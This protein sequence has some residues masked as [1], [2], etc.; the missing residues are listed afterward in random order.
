MNSLHQ[1]ILRRLQTSAAS[2][3]FTSHDFLNL[4]SRVAVNQALSR[5]A[6]DGQVVR[7]GRGIFY[8]PKINPRLGISVPPAPDDVADALARQTGSRI[9]PSGATAANRLGLSTQV[10]AKAVYL[11]DGRSHRWRSG[12][13]D[14]QF[15][16]VSPRNFRPRHPISLL[17]FQALKH[18]GKDGVGDTTL[19]ALQSTLTPDQ[20]NA[21]SKDSRHA[22]DWIANLIHRLDKSDPTVQN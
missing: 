1:S 17:V 12:V 5:L 4:G 14:I 7:V 15:K 3:V 9:L 2:M 21:L 10:P 22:P 13:W 20:K 19:A 16:H 6:H 11:T 18:L 8:L